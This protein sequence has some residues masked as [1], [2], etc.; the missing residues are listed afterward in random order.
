MMLIL[1]LI[2]ITSIND[3][4]EYMFVINVMM[5][6]YCNNNMFNKCLQIYK[7]LNEMNNNIKPGLLTFINL[8]KTAY[9]FGKM[10][11]EY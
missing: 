6:V 9:C 2:F 11:H 1:R 10:I 8:L 4:E 5:D 7:N 3:N